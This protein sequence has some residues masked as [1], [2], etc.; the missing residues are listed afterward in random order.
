[1][2]IVFKLDDILEFPDLPSAGK[3]GPSALS[4]SALSDVSSDPSYIQ[5]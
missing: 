4:V 3:L 2:I 1:M 5:R